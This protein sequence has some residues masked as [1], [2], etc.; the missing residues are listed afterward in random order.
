MKAFGLTVEVG[1]S[2][3][4]CDRSPCVSLILPL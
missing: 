2:E 1:T 3:P 4:V